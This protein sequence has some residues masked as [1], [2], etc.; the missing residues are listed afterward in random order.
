MRREEAIEIYK[1]E[2]QRWEST[3]S[4]Q[5]KFNIGLWTVL[6][7]AINFKKEL[8]FTEYDHTSYYSNQVCYYHVALLLSVAILAIHS[9]LVYL[10]QY[11]LEVSKE[12]CK[13]IRDDLNRSIDEKENII[14]I[15]P[16]VPTQK[17]P[18]FYNWIFLQVSITLLLYPLQIDFRKIRF[19][20]L[21][22]FRH[23]V[24]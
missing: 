17:G 2:M 12:I 9:W 21:E 23:Q 20:Y 19:D 10:I 8:G 11:S 16:K 22:V 13:N 5:W 3:R 24:F 18:N 7:L 15:I 6:A 1:T 14:F 4:I